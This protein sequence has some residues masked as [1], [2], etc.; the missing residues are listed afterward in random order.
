M[1]I[2]GDSAGGNLTLGITSLLAMKN[3][4]LPNGLSLYYP[5]VN[6]DRRSY[7]PSLNLSIDDIMLN[8]HYLPL[9]LDMYA[10]QEYEKHYLCSAKK[11][12][13]DVLK[14]FPPIK[15]I[16]AEND[17]LRDEILRF[18]LKLLK[19]NVRVNAWIY[20]HCFHGFMGHA[21][22]PEELKIKQIAINQATENL[23]FES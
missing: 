15:F 12:P 3:L 19:N 11:I 23:N 17:P 5:C 22:F 9:V 1:I 6:A 13:Q 2:E 16:I 4:N 20:R 8:Y 7:C 14:K 10:S 21:Y 18:M